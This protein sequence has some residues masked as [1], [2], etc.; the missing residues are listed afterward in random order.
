MWEDLAQARPIPS[1]R[2]GKISLF[3]SHLQNSRLMCPGLNFDFI[4]W[5]RIVNGSYAVDCNTCSR[6]GYGQNIQL[7]WIILLLLAWV[8]TLMLGWC[9]VFVLT[10]TTF[11]SVFMP[12]YKCGIRLFCTFRFILIFPKCFGVNIWRW[13]TE[14]SSLS[15]NENKHALQLF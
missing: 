4:S 6:L 1:K 2:L 10:H 3:H 14:L 12:S 11:Q 5:L 8:I 9:S 13:A 7:W 15:R